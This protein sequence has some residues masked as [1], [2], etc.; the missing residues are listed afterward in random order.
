MLAKGRP[1]RPF[2]FVSKIA[3]FPSESH[4]AGMFVDRVEVEL[5]AGK[6]GD[7]CVSFRREKFIPRG[8]PDGGDGGNGGSVVVVAEAGVDSWRPSHT[9][10]IGVQGTAF[11]AV[12]AIATERMLKTW[13]SAYRLARWFGMPSTISCSA[14]WPTQE[15]KWWQPEAAREARGVLVSRAHPTKFHGNSLPGARVSIAWWYSN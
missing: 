9:V 15:T 8:G 6:G 7:G 2:I 12:P 11:R 4:T 10:S 3:I 1:W 5:Q 13:S 14:T